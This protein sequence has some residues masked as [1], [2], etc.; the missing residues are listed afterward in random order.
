[1][2]E[3]CSSLLETGCMILINLS[4]ARQMEGFL[5]DP[6]ADEIYYFSLPYLCTPYIFISSVIV[7]C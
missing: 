1:M 2:T 6:T 7:R 4:W 3:N 5:F